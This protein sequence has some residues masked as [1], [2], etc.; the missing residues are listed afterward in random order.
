MQAVFTGW[1]Y[2]IT[3]SSL[4]LP[5]EWLYPSVS[6]LSRLGQEKLRDT[7][8]CLHCCPNDAF[9]AVTLFTA[10]VQDTVF[11]HRAHKDCKGFL[12][13][14]GICF[15]CLLLQVFCYKEI[16]SSSSQSLVRKL[17][18]E[19]GVE[20]ILLRCGCQKGLVL[21]LMETNSFIG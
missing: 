3:C 5:S 9:M 18:P 8:S 7:C 14:Q 19:S 17:L 10:C 13:F 11:T 16:L 2:S 20:F 1:V 21:L 15:L 4:D 6:E 12:T